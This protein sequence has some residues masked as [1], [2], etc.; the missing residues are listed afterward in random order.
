MARRKKEFINLKEKAITFK[1]TKGG[2]VLIRDI[3][4]DKIDFVKS[5]IEHNFHNE[6]LFSIEGKSI[7]K[8]LNRV[9]DQLG[10]ERHSNHDIRRLIAQEKYDSFRESGMSIK[11]SANETSK[12]FSHG[13]DRF[14]MLERSY[15]KLK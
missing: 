1:N 2:K 8:Y 7:N 12:W 13:D 14:N 6:R 10:L 5:V 3:P 15:I 11:E 9:Q 4:E